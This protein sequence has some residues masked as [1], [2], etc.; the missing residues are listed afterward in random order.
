MDEDI[1]SGEIYIC[2]VNVHAL[3]IIYLLSI[4]ILR[5]DSKYNIKNAVNASIRYY[6]LFSQI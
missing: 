4:L 6:V 1:R 3:F 2:V 5:K